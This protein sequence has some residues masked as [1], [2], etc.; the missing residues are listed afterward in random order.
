MKLKDF[1][2]PIFVK[3]LRKLGAGRQSVIEYKNYVEALK[4]CKTTNVC[5]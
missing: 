2:P 5:G 3:A 4:S 1:A